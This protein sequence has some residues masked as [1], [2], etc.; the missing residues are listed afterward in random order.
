MAIEAMSAARVQQPAI[1]AQGG[2]WTA[3]RPRS[4]WAESNLVL[5]RKGAI[6]KLLRRAAMSSAERTADI[7]A[8][9]D[10]IF[11]R[12][13]VFPD[14]AA[15]A[16]NI[17]F[18]G[19]R[20]YTQPYYD[21]LE[22]GGGTCW[23]IDVDPA[24]ATFGHSSRHATASVLDVHTLNTGRDFATI[25]LA[26]VLGYGVNRR[27]EQLAAIRACGALLAD[28]G[29]LV[30]SWNDRRLHHGVIEDALHELEF[31]TLPELPPRLW[32]KGCDQ[33]FAF[34]ARKTVERPVETLR[35]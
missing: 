9:P 17:L 34:L 4:W 1:N 31:T 15:R 18:V 5:P 19:V 14:A 29:V 28:D 30:L 11:M 2:T 25:I 16:G 10:R 6:T 24:A 22:A 20:A 13:Y 35:N 33:Q 3:D 23:T 27:S 26:G 21:L 7:A 12:R 32:L 8:A